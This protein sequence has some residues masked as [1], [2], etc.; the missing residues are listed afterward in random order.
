MSIINDGAPV[1]MTSATTDGT[2]GAG[3]FNMTQQTAA[4]TA[5]T[6]GFSLYSD[7]SNNMSWRE[8]A[9]KAFKL[10]TS[11]ATTSRTWALPDTSDSILT[12]TSTATVSNKT[13]SSTTNT[14]DAGSLKTFP[15]T[16]TFA[17]G[18]VLAYGTSA[19]EPLTFSAT[20][21]ATYSAG[22]I[23]VSVGS[24]AGTAAAG[25]D[26][27]FSSPQ[28]RV[29]KTSGAGAGEYT[30]I[31]AALA[32]I[33]DAAA[34]K[35]YMVEV[36][37]GHY[38][39]DNFTIPAY[40]VVSG[41]G[42]GES[43][44]LIPS[45]PG[46]T[47]VTL[48]T[49]GGLNGCVLSSDGTG[50]A[51]LADSVGT[52][53]VNNVVFS[54]FT[55]L[56]RAL[57]STATTNLTMFD[58][59]LV[60]PFTTGVYVD[61]TAANSSFATAVTVSSITTT[62]DNSV[63]SLLS[64]EGPLAT[65]TIGNAYITGG[66]SATG[67]LFSDGATVNIQSAQ[68]SGCN[69]GIT[70]ANVGAGPILRAAGV[71]VV[72]SGNKD[73][74]LLHPS[75]DGVFEGSVDRTKLELN[76]TAPIALQFIDHITNGTVILGD[77]AY[78]PS[79]SATITDIGDLIE[80]SADLGTYTGGAV[81]VNTGTSVAVSAGKGYVK[82]GTAPNDY[83]VKLT[84]SST[85]VALSASTTHYVHVN[86][87][88]TLTSST[89]FPDQYA[90][91]VL[92]RV[93]TTATGIEFIDSQLYASRHPDEA[94]RTV[95][96][97]AIG[98][99]YASGSVVTADASRQLAISSGRYFYLNN[100]FTPAGISFGTTWLAYYHVAGEWTRASQ[101]AVSN[102][103]YDNGTDLASLTAGN[104]VK[105]SVYTVGNTANEQYFLVYGQAEYADLNSAVAATLPVPPNYFSE[106]IVLIAAVICQQ[107]V[108]TV[109]QIIN[110]KPT[111]GS[112]SSSTGSVTDHGQLTGLLDD[113]HTQYLL[114]SGTRA[115]TS[116][117]DMGTNAITNVGLVDGVDVSAHA[118]RHLPNGAD[119][120]TTAA[121][122]TT[123]TTATTN[124]VGT[125]NSFARSDHTHAIDQT[126]FALNS[127]GGTL[128]VAKGGTGATTLTAGNF[129][130][131]AGT[132]AVD[133]T[134]VAPS[135][136]V[137][138]TTDTQTLTNKT[139]I[140]STNTI[141]ASALQTT[142]SAV[143]VSGSA[144][145]TAGQA[146]VATSATTAAWSAPGAALVDTSTFIVD[147]VD[148]TK[149]VGFDAGG[150]TATTTTLAFAQTAD[151]TLTFP[152]ATDTMV[153][154][155]TTDTLT[156]KTLTDASCE[157]ADSADATKRVAIDAGGTTS[158]K[159]TLAFAQTA[160]R[161]LTMPNAT[162]TLVGRTTT[163]TLTNKALSDTT[164]TVISAADA[165]KVL[166]FSL[167]GA[168]AGATT[169]I[170]PTS[171]VSRTLSLPDATDTVVTE[172]FLATLSNKNLVDANVAFVDDGDATKILRAQLAG[173]N[174]GTTV[175]L[176]TTATAN[177]T[178]TLPDATDTIVAR[179][180]IDTLTN[181]TITGSTNTVD[182]NALKTTGASV[183][184]AS[185]SPPT[186]GQALIATSATT[187]AWSAPG[188][189]L[190]DNATFVV[191]S[192]DAT[193]RVGFDAGGTTGTTSTLVFAQ[194]AD[195]TLSFPDATTTMVG[196]DTTQT[197]TNKTLTNANNTV[198]AAGLH[199]T[200]TPVVVSAAVAPTAGQALVATSGTAAAW[201]T[202]WDNLV[203]NVTF[204]VDNVDATRR[205]NFSVAG[206]T[207]TTTTLATAPTDNR[208][209]SLPDAT[210]TLV[211]RATTDTM[212]NKTI[213]GSTN[214]VEAAA[215]RNNASAVYVTAAAPPSAGQALVAT[216]G[217]TAAWSAP[218]AAMIDNLTYV[219][220]NVDPTKR[221]GFDAGGT[222]GTT[223]TMTFAQTADRT[224]T[225]PDV[226]DTI[227][228]RTTTDVMSNK[229]LLTTT[230]QFADTAD[231]TK[232]LKFT[233]ALA[234][235]G[236]ATTIRA[237]QTANRTLILPDATDTLVGRATVDT[238]DNKSISTGTCVLIDETDATKQ[239]GFELVGATPTTT[240]TLAANQSAN[241]TITFPDATD[242]L[243]GRTTTDTLANKTLQST[244]CVFADTTDLT[245]RIEFAIGGA[246]TA[247]KT[248]IAANQTI[249]RT[250]TLPDITDTLVSK[251][252]DDIL[253]NKDLVDDST[254]IIDG[255]DNTRRIGFDV[256]GASGTTMT[257][258]SNPSA[259]RVITMPDATDVIVARN[260]SDILSNKTLVSSSVTFCASDSVLKR[261]AFEIS[262]SSLSTTTTLAFAQTANRTITFQDSSDTVVGRA[263]TDTLTNKTLTL[264]VISQ[265]VNTGT[266]TL[267][268]S[269]DTLVGRA[270]TDT[271]TNKTLT[272]ATNTIEASAVQTTGAPVV[273][274][275]SAPPAGAG[276]SLVTTSA[277]TA[278]WSYTGSALIDVNT[279]IVDSVD[280]TKRIGFDAGGT[281]GTTTTLVSVQT[282]NRSLTLPDAS[283]TLVARAT[284]DTLQNKTLLTPVIAQIINTG[285]LTLPTTTDTLVGRVTTDTLTNKTLT[286][287]V[288]AQIVNVGTL[289]LPTAT[290]TLVART[291]TD[292]LTNK[293]ITGSTN[294]VD[295]N[296]LKTTGSSVTVA[297][298]GPPTSG[299]ALIATSA[300][301]ASWQTIT[302]PL[303]FFGNLRYSVGTG[304]PGTITLTNAATWYLVNTAGTV[305]S[306][307]GTIF[308]TP[309]NG[310]LTY[311]GTPSYSQ[312]KLS[313]TFHASNLINTQYYVSVFK[314]GSVINDSIRGLYPAAA[315]T[316]AAYT[317][318]GDIIVS[319]ATN[320]YFEFYAQTSVST[321]QLFGI[322]AYTLHAQPLE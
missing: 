188:A 271:L 34:N 167:T 240:L 5:P 297:S 260:T 57:G 251:S 246:T 250:I 278:A 187:A 305:S 149:R 99:L 313:F 80:S 74:R 227:V 320:D 243:V 103:Q 290:D 217:T 128:G 221:I 144:P 15:I 157:F 120:L 259:N 273:V 86:A 180:T 254:F 303:S 299:Q 316:N 300:T 279:F 29:V 85:T 101:S 196:T 207:A 265:I 54:G 183:T 308:S 79:N 267:P 224:L 190:V 322:A 17:D 91:L 205:V 106:G 177:H 153:G 100:L 134:K 115:M 61:G 31:A 129:L 140:G 36:H 189:A 179:A 56:I 268:T 302:T 49:D 321:G 81:T 151:R 214:T 200:T 234:T 60:A 104:Y 239:I 208:T 232:Q 266:L 32:S 230:S 141:D 126:T 95:F 11:A 175:T 218:G 102:S 204:V 113:D 166:A 150:T 242:T 114:V 12:T 170:S 211:G 312:V 291:T 238:L 252:S 4:P 6:S 253:A 281:T 216:S 110:L 201:S 63:V 315:S 72:N 195:R 46:G 84:W 109:T 135:G 123:L 118:S 93:R 219:V 122:L 77:L 223:T 124:A 48:S 288:I 133:T 186:A 38:T 215:I 68:I 147:D 1:F 164:T 263:T 73:L 40:V 42:A 136:I 8:P 210:D 41:S 78:A 82:A 235:T 159:T 94:N 284:T 26:A 163:D 285:T 37:P 105:H 44:V 192:T 173:S 276:M 185:A 280:A 67:V 236:T 203:D 206:T 75:V 20:A 229:T 231:Q 248:T 160:N 107:G 22:V 161:T 142:G 286:L 51:I 283:D 131:G 191:D 294:V 181:K 317:V 212:T 270:T 65:L 111:V 92:A 158:T 16:G 45:T 71:T 108:S 304:T 137:I 314:N 148:A 156:N 28:I 53:F 116:S 139:I 35:P 168:T 293:T 209:L 69:N 176:A 10:D 301:A 289:T 97:E 213:T 155:A 33:T 70:A 257:I 295:A 24:T 258:F 220:D 23:G 311:V 298:A 9:G 145:P 256:A 19:W 169:T 88:G 3:F 274:S 247:T 146:L 222:T 272:G 261:V 127:I 182:A 154:R 172:A 269:T 59:G 96:R 165:T 43:T 87:S 112:T 310:R 198:Y 193:K 62:P 152:D 89:S 25:N 162:D 55:T 14:V 194:T 264:P 52:V 143:V 262:A 39:I 319:L 202:P 255:A 117:L 21:P 66:T 282:A 199:T 138:G 226:T 245:K 121:P 27:R 130:I 58:C 306:R 184:V 47:F 2:A 318:A 18:D 98:V 64:A 249:N 90:N 225:F 287:P 292:T 30:T 125:A 296:A 277:T 76:A 50:T 244:T 119:P 83:L 171:T 197:L 7:T 132:S 275:G 228:A 307:G 309:A 233:T 237:S 13:I 178:L 174:T 241:R